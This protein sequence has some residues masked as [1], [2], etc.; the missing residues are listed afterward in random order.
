M[1][2]SR[3]TEFLG[4]K[5]SIALTARPALIGVWAG[6]GLTDALLDKTQRRTALQPN[7][8]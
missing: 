1:D 4:E 6:A 8:S 5:T 2:P 7:T 3:P